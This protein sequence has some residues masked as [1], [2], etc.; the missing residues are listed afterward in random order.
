M[1]LSQ[2][3]S[4]EIAKTGPVPFRRFMELALYH[5]AHG[6]Y[7]GGRAVVG[8]RGDFITSVS[9]GAV[10]GRLLTDQF[11]EMWRLLD[12]PALFTIVEQGADSG[13]FARDVLEAAHA[14][15][16]FQRA[17]R[18]WIVEPFPA[19]EARQKERLRTVQDAPEV[20]WFPTLEELPPFSGVHFSN[21]LID[22]MP[23]HRV[24]FRGGEW[25]EVHV[26]TAPEIGTASEPRFRFTDGP[27]SDPALKPFLAHLPQKEGYA[28]EINLAAH[29][30]LAQVSTACVSRSW[31]VH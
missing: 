3:L 7:S 26:A 6:Y 24:V 27:L 8:M 17:L 22:A 21:E 15:P 28:T 20:R 9:A 13:D 25:R 10:F 29:H 11:E 5:P 16:E 30:W 2:S 23:V 18:Y 19:N 14:F 31:L 1:P 4:D 12:R